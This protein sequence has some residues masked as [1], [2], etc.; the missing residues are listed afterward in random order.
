MHLTTTVLILL[1]V[2]AVTNLAVT[3]V[4]VPLPLLQIAIGALI[5]LAGFHVSFDPSLFLLLFIPPLLFADAYRIPKR[6]LREVGIPVMALA[7]GLVL[8]TVVGIG[9]FVHWLLPFVP[10][11]AA[12][13][14]AAVLS[15][16]DAVALGGIMNGRAMPR[17]FMHILQGEALLNDASGL[18]SFNF[19][20]TAVMA[21]TFSLSHA[22]LSFV[23]V[24]AGG[25]AVGMV[26]GW[27]FFQLDRH[28]LARR[29]DEASI[30]ILLIL[31]LPFAA[32][33][34]AGA[35]DV[36]GILAA[37]AT[38]LT[39]N[40]MDPFG[41]TSGSIRRRT[42]AIWSTL[43][44]TF[45]GLI[46][47]L[48][49][50]QLPHILVDGLRITTQSHHT[51][52][53][54][55]LLVVIITL[56]L[57]VLR[58]IWVVL[59]TILRSA[60]N[61]ASGRTEGLPFPGF[62]VISVTSVAGVRGAVTLAGILSLPLFLPDGRGFPNRN[63]LISIS[64]GVI[65]LSLLLAVVTL[66]A[67]IKR[68]PDTG[69]TRVEDEIAV[70]RRQM[71]EGAIREIEARL[72]LGAGRRQG[73]ARLAYEEAASRVLADYRLKL[74]GRDDDDENQAQAQE[75]QRAEVAL[76]LRGVRA[77]RA[78]MRA[79]RQRHAINDEAVQLLIE[80][81]DLEEETLSHIARTLPQKQ[82]M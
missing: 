38:G 19:A 79:L 62:L 32:Y 70:A 46:F 56:A 14:L 73:A 50:L 10:L 35:L 75:D 78:E 74:P 67:L 34:T 28:V 4:R 77:E 22:A 33:L 69:E 11:A 20:V 43:E 15:P 12:F 36:S 71:A 30:Y 21:G 63:L 41:G 54:L 37:V 23:I 39:L 27:G 53:D 40:A 6:E 45:N 57:V 16:T 7:F 44:F 82:A 51:P 17:R 80:E 13:A 2:T 81:L 64:A 48:L 3:V 65:I 31:L 1:F 68:L 76:R 55:L 8:F 29:P 72:P 49:G 60:V 9:S 59:A 5:D 58:F 47:L 24:A 52:W 26:Y 66:P 42:F 61:R 25:V 18:V